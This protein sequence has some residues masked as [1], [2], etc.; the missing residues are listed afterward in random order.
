M[1]DRS[2]KPGS[3]PIGSL[4]S[5]ITSSLR[6]VD[7]TGS[8]SPMKPRSS[9][10]ATSPMPRST[11]TGT[12]P[13]GTGS[14][15]PMTSPGAMAVVAGDL[16]RDPGRLLKLL[17]TSLLAS[18]W[19]TTD[20]DGYGMDVQPIGYELVKPISDDDRMQLLAIVEKQLEP[21]RPEMVVAELARVRALTVSRDQSTHDLELVAAAYAV[22]LRQYPA[23]VVKQVL[24]AWPRSH[25]F[26]PALAELIEPM[27]RMMRPLQ[28]QA[29]AL[30]RGYHPPP[31]PAPPPSDE[32]KAAVT[33]LLKERGL[34]VD[35]H[36]RTRPI[37][38]TPEDRAKRRQAVEELKTFRLP[39]DDDPAVQARLRQMGV[40]C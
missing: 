27:D 12:P 2:P 23:E 22:E 35:H 32:D 3:A 15:E 36:G 25:R 14:S 30:R 18:R 26:W 16:Q 13:G 33:E 1:D 7:G 11:P 6:I 8:A 24:R 37:E 5:K 39:D 9:D 29:A 10:P 19:V 21:A 38:E 17:A 4:T 34:S 28:S 20:T 40:S 31:Q